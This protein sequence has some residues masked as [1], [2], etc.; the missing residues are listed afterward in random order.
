MVTWRS[1]CMHHCDGEVK[2]KSIVLDVAEVNKA[3]NL[4][5][6]LLIISTNDDIVLVDIGVNN[7]FRQ[8]IL[9]ENIFG[10]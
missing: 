9:Q 3:H 1:D 6:I 8:Q 5:F 4:D 10:G 7:A 2:H